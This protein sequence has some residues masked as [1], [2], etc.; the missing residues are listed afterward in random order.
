M[1]KGIVVKG[2]V[3]GADKMQCVLNS[4]N[5]PASELFAIIAFLHGGRRK[6]GKARH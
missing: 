3:Y 6:D 4:K 2:K 1:L 5:K